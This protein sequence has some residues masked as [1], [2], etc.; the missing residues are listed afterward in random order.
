MLPNHGYEILGASGPATAG[1]PEGEHKPIVTTG[2]VVQQ[3]VYFQ[4]YI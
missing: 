2:E 3:N 1:R 4:G